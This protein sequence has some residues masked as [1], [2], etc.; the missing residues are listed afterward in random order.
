MKKSICKFILKILG[1][2]ADVT[3]PDFKKCVIIVAPH[4]SNW[5]F[6]LGEIYYASAGR[7]AEILM[8]KEWFFFPMNIILKCIGV[9]PVNRGKNMSMTDQLIER[10][11]QQDEFHLA[12]TPEGTRSA[13]GRWK[14]GF[15]YIALG[16]KIPIVAYAIDYSQK[17]IIGKKVFYPTGDFDNEIK[18]IK[19]YYSQFTGKKP[20]NFKI[21]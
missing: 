10:A 20:E 6:L 2:K 14:S 17:I 13:N 8:K 15:Y 9:I 18:E 5:D 12:I 11:K 4:T 3:V 1:W 21:K 7:K 19:T 16:A